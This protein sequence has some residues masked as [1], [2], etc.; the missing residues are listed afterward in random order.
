MLA[1]ADDDDVLPVRLLNSRFAEADLIIDLRDDLL[2]LVSCGRDEGISLDVSLM[3]LLLPA[4]TTPL[5]TL[6]LLP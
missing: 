5:I 1:A 6:G 2:L 3:L 4:A